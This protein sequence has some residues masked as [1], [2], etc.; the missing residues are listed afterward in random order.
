MHTVFIPALHRDLTDGVDM[1]TA[2]GA[3]VGQLLDDLDR[4]YPGIKDRLCQNDELR[5]GIAVAVDGVIS[6][7]GLRHRLD[8]PSEVH[9]IPAMAGGA[10]VRIIAEANVQ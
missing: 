4:R 2:E 8:A 5:A 7:R 10:C 9:F 3:T 6:R 1:A